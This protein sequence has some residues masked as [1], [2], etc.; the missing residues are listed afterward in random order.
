MV[1]CFLLWKWF[2]LLRK[3]FANIP[4][5]TDH[6]VSSWRWVSSVFQ[7]T[8]PL[9]ALHYRVWRTC[10]SF[11]HRYGMLHCH[12]IWYVD[13][14]LLL[15]LGLQLEDDQG[16]GLFHVRLLL[17]FRGGLA[18][19]WIRFV[20]L[21]DLIWLSSDA[22]KIPDTLHSTTRKSPGKIDFQMLGGKK[23]NKPCTSTAT[24]HKKTGTR[25]NSEEKEWLL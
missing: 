23:K 18:W 10:S 17:H 13:V 1:L 24:M 15:H 20:R 11:S 2:R 14:G 3:S 25:M 8:I 9:A 22:Q 16:H 6:S 21:P 12:P 19:I 7:I 5:M 4:S